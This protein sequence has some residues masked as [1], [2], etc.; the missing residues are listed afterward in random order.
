LRFF[1]DN[2][3]SINLAEGVRVLAR[4]QGYEIVHLS[5]KFP[6]DAED[7]D[8]IPALAEEG[9]WV[10]VSADPRI[11]RSKAERAAWRE[12]NL[13]AFFFSEGFSNKQY[14]KQAEILVHWWPL[15]VLKSRQAPSG[16]GFLMPLAG[17]EFKEVY[18]PLS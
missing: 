16:S 15:M 13:T 8:W 2:C 5:E 9:D 10:I 18:S 12:S 14:W 17:K 7:L 6:A 3:I 1:I 4:V 11:S